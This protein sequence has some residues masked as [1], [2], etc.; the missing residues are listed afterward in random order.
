[1]KKIV[2]SSIEI[3]VAISS[4]IF[5]SIEKSLKIPLIIKLIINITLI[6]IMIFLFVSDKKKCQTNTPTVFNYIKTA[7]A[8][9]FVIGIIVCLVVNV[10]K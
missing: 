9:L 1:M 7:L 2:K 6:L 3:I 5:F 8:I 4:L 10:N